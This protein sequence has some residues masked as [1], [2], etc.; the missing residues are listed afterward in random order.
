MVEQK[1]IKYSSGLSQQTGISCY[2]TPRSCAPRALPLCL[3]VSRLSLPRF[4]YGLTVQRGLSLSVS[5][6]A[7]G[8]RKTPILGLTAR[9]RP[10]PM[11]EVVAGCLLLGEAHPWV[12]PQR[13]APR[14]PVG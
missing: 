14:P 10:R 3:G 1:K 2:L 4:R 6:S 7:S 9:Y 12:G 5:V 13:L 11:R 8:S